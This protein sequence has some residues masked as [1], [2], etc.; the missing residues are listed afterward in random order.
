MSKNEMN[1]EPYRKRQSREVRMRQKRKRKRKKKMIRAFLLA[2]FLLVLAL[3]LT[4]GMMLGRLLVNIVA[5]R[6]TTMAWSFGSVDIV[7]DAG[8]G[9]KDQGTSYESI[10]EKDLTLEI[11]EKARDIL[12][13]AGYNVGMVRRDD[14]FVA[15][16]ERAEYANRKN[17][18][19]YVSIHCNSSEDGEGNG[20]ETFYAEQKGA[21]SQELAQA[22]QENVINQTKARDREVKTADYT[23][24]VQTEMPAALVEIGF[25]SDANERALLQQ[26]EY[27][28]KL[29]EG[30]ASGI[31]EYMEKR[32]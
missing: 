18:K 4:A 2:L 24:I 23:V 14:T 28:E 19:A 15:L 25:L 17:A 27:Q 32:E 29:A 13:E 5:N 11:T 21:E 1:K 3:V 22:I 8:H 20:I 9:G 16:D 12:E 6:E 26:E 10:I 30:I 31:I 7:L